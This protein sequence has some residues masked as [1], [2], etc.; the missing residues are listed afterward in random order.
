VIKYSNE[1]RDTTGILPAKVS[2]YPKS[3]KKFTL[4]KKLTQGGKKFKRKGRNQKFSIDKP[5]LDFQ[6][7]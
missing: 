1:Y 6:S 5:Q 7:I 4:L 2:K 3:C